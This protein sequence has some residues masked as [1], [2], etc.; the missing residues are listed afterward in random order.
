[1]FCIRAAVD[2]LLTVDIQLQIACHLRGFELGGYLKNDLLIMTSSPLDLPDS[3]ST[4]INFLRHNKYIWN[5]RNIVT[6]S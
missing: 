1:M 6:L 2:S 5:M 3:Y 4:M